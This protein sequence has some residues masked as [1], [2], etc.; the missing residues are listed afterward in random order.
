M[1]MRKLILVAVMQVGA[2]FILNT[3]A[4]AVPVDHTTT[5]SD[6]LTTGLWTPG[7]VTTTQAATVKA[8]LVC[9]SVD[10]GSCYKAVIDKAYLFSYADSILLPEV[11][12]TF[13]GGFI[14]QAFHDGGKIHE[15]WH[16][17]YIGALLNSTYGAL[18]VWSATYESCLASSV[19][20]ALAKGT[21][22]LANALTTATNAFVADF[23]T[24]VTNP[25]FG[26]QNAIATIKNI[27][28]VNTWVGVNDNWGQAAVDYAN[29]I[30]VSFSKSPGNCNCIPEPS[31]VMLFAIGAIGFTCTQKKRRCQ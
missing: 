8:E 17:D 16:K 26:H 2:A 5:Y 20:A 7:S 18:E 22:D 13:N 15:D 19:A 30:K 1:K 12:K 28:G 21:A 25:A 10:G 4:L 27:G 24:D 29:G 3:Q 31:I 6:G 9:E 11:G 23:S 14:N